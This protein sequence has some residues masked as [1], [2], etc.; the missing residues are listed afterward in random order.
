M[1][2]EFLREIGL[3][4]GGIIIGATAITSVFKPR[5]KVVYFISIVAAVIVT[6]TE[7]YL[8]AHTNKSLSD[9]IACMI[10]SGSDYCV[11][12]DVETIASSTTTKSQSSSL[13]G[14]WTI[15]PLVD[16]NWQTLSDMDLSHFV[17]RIHEKIDHKDLHFQSS[18][19]IARAMPLS[20]IDYA[21]LYEIEI[22]N[23]GEAKLLQAYISIPGELVR[24]DGTNAPIY[25][26]GEKGYLD[27]STK[28]KATDYI[29]FFFSYVA[30]RN[31]NFWLVEGAKDFRWSNADPKK[32]YAAI[33]KNR[34]KAV[35]LARPIQALSYD[36]KKK[37]W[38]FVGTMTF[39]DSFFT[40]RIKVDSY[41][42]FTLS[43]EK[44]LVEN[45]PL[46]ERKIESTPSGFRIWWQSYP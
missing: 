13:S 11:P 46:L 35:K 9:R 30:G 17:D 16:G 25:Y 2:F 34:E 37:E 33:N 31:G 1:I 22:R 32:S 24:L 4:I 20:F 38:L 42:Y 45:L 15:P 10:F 21:S 7:Y 39:K 27:L 19:A 18:E 3:L 5:K 23:R 29:R 14:N 44:T 40:N 43:D 8:V 12:A 36:S 26:L 28:Q 6:L 41:G